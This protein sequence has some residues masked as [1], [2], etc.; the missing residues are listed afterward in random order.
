MIWK[1]GCPAC[2]AV[3]AAFPAYSPDI[4][5]FSLT[6][7]KLKVLIGALLLMLFLAGCVPTVDD[8]FQLPVPKPEYQELQNEIT[9]RLGE[10]WE[11]TYPLGGELRTT[12]HFADLTGDG[13]EEGVILLRASESSNMSIVT[14]A[15]TGERYEFMTEYLL[16]GSAF[17]RIAFNDIDG[18]GDMEIL[19]GIQYGTEAL[20]NAMLLDLNAETG[21]L[22]SLL[23]VPY[24]DWLVYNADG[25]ENDELLILQNSDSSNDATAILYA[26]RDGKAVELGRAPLSIGVTKPETIVWGRIQTGEVIAVVES[27]YYVSGYIADPL[28]FYKGRFFNMGYDPEL[29]INNNWLMPFLLPAADSDGDGFIELPNPQDV[30][31]NNGSAYYRI[32]WFA[33]EPFGGTEYEFST[34]HD[35]ESGWYLVFPAGWRY[36]LQIYTRTDSG[37]VR[38]TLFADLSGH[39][40]LECNLYPA[41]RSNL[42]P[43]NNETVIFTVNGNYL[44]VVNPRDPDDTERLSLAE[45]RRLLHAVE[46]VSLPVPSE[47]GE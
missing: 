45:A 29:K 2:G 3:S 41:R 16:T 37:G 6:L 30:Q 42:I 5:R 1:S 19:V 13:R 31:N 40:L 12:M 7:K 10:G 21:E 32:D 34:Y 27:R 28:I 36:N 35:T 15:D 17:S 20:Y 8:L 46:D 47:S 39:T 44:T 9:R 25:D 24:T 23:K 33:L 11:L 43:T 38:R 4:R 14:Y 22:E 18:D 26:F